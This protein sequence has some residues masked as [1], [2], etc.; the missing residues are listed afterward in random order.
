MNHDYSN[1]I[2]LSHLRRFSVIYNCVQVVDH[3]NDSNN[4]HRIKYKRDSLIKKLYSRF[5][6]FFIIIA[7][8]RLTTF[9]DTLTIMAPQCISLDCDIF[10]WKTFLPRKL[11]IFPLNT[12]VTSQSLQLIS[13]YTKFETIY[14]SFRKYEL[15][16]FDVH[17][18]VKTSDR[19][20]TR[21][22]T[23]NR[24]WRPHQEFWT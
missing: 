11:L 6:W 16:G 4:Q 10:W 22:W 19:L 1:S 3:I 17:N 24:E 15:F 18:V 9:C 5:C 2:V 21:A 8:S 20:D 23:L 14:S 12:S 13:I 7:G